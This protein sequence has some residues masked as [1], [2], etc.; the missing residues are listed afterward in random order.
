MVLIVPDPATP[1]TAVVHA[2]FEYNVKATVPVGATEV[3]PTNVAESFVGVIAVPTVPVS[4][5]AVVVMVGETFETLN[6]SQLL[7]DDE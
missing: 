7:F 4:G 2:L 6:G 1:V 3:V 5:D